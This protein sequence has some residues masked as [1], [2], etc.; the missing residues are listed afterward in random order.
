MT[1]LDR[2]RRAWATAVLIVA[3]RL[4][5]TTVD[6][7]KMLQKKAAEAGRKSPFP[8]FNAY[9]VYVTRHRN[10][11]T[12]ESDESDEIAAI[13]EDASAIDKGG[14]RE[15]EVSTFSLLLPDGEATERAATAEESIEF[16]KRMSREISREPAVLDKLLESHARMVKSGDGALRRF[17]RHYDAM[18]AE[19]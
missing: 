15:P 13:F 1:P 2:A 8:S 11:L 10:S 19:V 3:E 6:A 16:V 18:L 4:E 14:I 7:Y 17:L 5:I 12:L 9:K